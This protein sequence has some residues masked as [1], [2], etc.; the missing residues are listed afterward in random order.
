MK[1]MLKCLDKLVP[2]FDE[3]LSMT[4]Q[5]RKRVFSGIQPSGDLTIGNYIGA[6]RQWVQYQEEFDPLYC[7]VDLHAITAGHYLLY[8]LQKH[9]R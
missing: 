6:I 1:P 2:F 8:W 5:K 7:V 9:V 4:D 3:G